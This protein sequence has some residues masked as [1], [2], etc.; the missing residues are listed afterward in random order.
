MT[1]PIRNIRSA[2]PTNPAKAYPRRK[3][4]AITSIIVHHSLT[5]TGSAA[6]Y[7]RFHISQYGWPGIAYHYV[8]DPDGTVNQTLGLTKIGYHCAGMNTK[9]VGVVLTGNFD[10]TDPTP[11]QME[12]LAQLTV[13]I[14]KE[15]GRELKVERHSDYSTKTCPGTRFPWLDLKERIR[16]LEFVTTPPEPEDEPEPNVPIQEPEPPAPD[17]PTEPDPIPP[18]EVAVKLPSG[19]LGFKIF[20]K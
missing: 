13:H 16:I 9:G 11:A 7:A 2:I 12:S 20:A 5:K 8:I 6:A 4:S 14:E 17:K 10:K 15:I 1:L 18:P 19:C 3:L